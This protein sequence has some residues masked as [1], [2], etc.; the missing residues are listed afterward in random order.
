MTTRTVNNKATLATKIVG[1]LAHDNK[2]FNMTCAACGGMY[3]SY[4]TNICPKCGAALVHITSNGKN[5]TI[6]EGTIFPSLGKA[7]RE[8]Y[9][10]D[11]RKRKNSMPIT[12]RF[13]IFSFAEPGQSI[14]PPIHQN[15]KKNT[16]VEVLCIN[17]PP[18]ASWYTDKQGV[19]HVELMYMIFDK[20]GDTVRVMDDQKSVATATTTYNVDSNGHPLAMATPYPEAAAAPAPAPT[21]PAPQN[22]VPPAQNAAAPTKSMQELQAEYESLAQAVMALKQSIEAGNTASQSTEIPQQVVSAYNDEVDPF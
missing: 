16:L 15:L 12:Y 18:I 5:M 17:H 21:A 7:T 10:N 22:V 8:K 4:E 9:E 3:S 20:Y 19:A 6:S 14:I 11:M 2:L 13:K 1:W